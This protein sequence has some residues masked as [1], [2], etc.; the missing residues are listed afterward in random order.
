MEE[1]N[2]PEPE[3]A[4]QPTSHKL[5]EKLAAKHMSQVSNKPDVQTACGGLTGSSGGA[6]GTRG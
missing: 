6:L 5:L 3:P 2:R 1:F 4:R